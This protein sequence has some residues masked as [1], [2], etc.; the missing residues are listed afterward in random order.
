[1]K[2]VMT[3]ATIY[4]I[5]LL[6]GL[7]WQTVSSAEKDTAG[8]P[9]PYILADKARP[10]PA[11]DHD[12][13]KEAFADGGCAACHHVL[14]EETGKLVYAEEDAAACIECHEESAADGIPGIRE[15]AHE[16]CTD[17]H[18]RMIKASRKTGPTTCGQCHSK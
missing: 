18:R 3:G 11:F 15:A 9:G 17:C 2:K 16:S 4:L 8:N 13:H 10:S 14:D 7:G 6:W 5:C 1:M 12:R